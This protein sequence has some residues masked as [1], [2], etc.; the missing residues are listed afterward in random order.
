VAVIALLGAEFLMPIYFLALRG[1]TAFETGIILPAL[2]VAAG[3]AAPTARMLYDHIGPRPLVVGGFGLLLFNTWQLS[4][5]QA[6]TP[7][8]YIAFLLSVRGLGLRMSVQTTLST[9]L[10]NIPPP[11]LARGSTLVNSTRS[12]VQWGASP[13]WQRTSRA[14]SRRSL[15]TSRRRHRS[16]A[17]LRRLPAGVSTCARRRGQPQPKTF[18]QARLPRFR[19]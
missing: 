1:R 18:R 19:V 7:I 5:A 6:D 9:A 2:A 13:C 8:Q 12:L 10:A 15:R 11:L 14:R 4:Q 3:V 16:E 17:S